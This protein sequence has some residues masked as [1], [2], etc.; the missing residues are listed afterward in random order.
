[1]EKSKGIYTLYV[2][3]EY[4]YKNPN[5]IILKSLKYLRKQRENVPSNLVA[6]SFEAKELCSTPQTH[7]PRGGKETDVVPMGAEVAGLEGHRK[8]LQGASFPPGETTL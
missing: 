6:F 2:L 8:H 3:F 5:I 4:S 1:M 7:W